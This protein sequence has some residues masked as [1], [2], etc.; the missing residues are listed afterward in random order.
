MK[1]LSFA[2]ALTLFALC[3]L[4]FHRA[5]V[6]QQKQVAWEGALTTGDKMHIVKMEVLLDACQPGD[7]I[8]LRDGGL[9]AIVPSQYE[10]GSLILVRSKDGWETLPPFDKRD[11]RSNYAREVLLW[12][13]DRVYK[14]ID[15]E[16]PEIIKKF[17]S[18]DCS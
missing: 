1:T 3:F 7:V 2:A 18:G 10:H 16:Y 11:K 6:S 4:L 12:G 14:P 13:M 17:L 8:R 15:P 5:C 9:M